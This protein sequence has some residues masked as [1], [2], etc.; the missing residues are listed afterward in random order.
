MEEALVK[1]EETFVTDQEA[2]EVA[3]VGKDPLDLPAFGVTPQSA[4]IVTEASRRLRLEYN[5]DQSPMN[6]CPSEMNSIAVT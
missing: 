6:L 4:P 3:Q 2:A 5:H 1:R